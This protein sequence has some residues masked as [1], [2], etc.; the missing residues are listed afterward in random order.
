MT[1]RKIYPIAGALVYIIS[2]EPICGVVINKIFWQDQ[3]RKENPEIIEECALISK[4]KNIIPIFILGNTISYQ[5]KDVK[6]DDDFFKSMHIQRFAF[7]SIDDVQI[8]AGGFSELFKAM[9]KKNG[10]FEKADRYLITVKEDLGYLR[11][12][13]TGNYEG[14]NMCHYINRWLDFYERALPGLKGTQKKL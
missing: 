3:A 7:S 13:L 9:E 1:S 4:K 2:N 5:F 6:R 11:G 8:I 14:L 10:I 12:Y